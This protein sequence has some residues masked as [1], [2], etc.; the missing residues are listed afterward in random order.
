M[1]KIDVYS[2]QA[3][4]RFQEPLTVGLVGAKVRLS[5]SNRWEALVKTVVFRQGDITR[6][7]AGV[8]GSAVIPWEVIHQPGI[9]VEIG[10]YGTDST[11]TVVI[12]TVWVRTDPVCAA[13]DPEQ[14]PSTAPSLEVWAQILAKLGNLDALETEGRTD[15][16]SAINEVK[17]SVCLVRVTG[18]GDACT[19]DRT[20]QELNAAYS[21]GKTL[22]C[23]WTE[24]S[25]FL[26]LAV[27][28]QE[29]FHFVTVVQ[30]TEYDVR[31]NEDGIN[32]GTIILA[33]DQDKLPNPNKLTFTGAVEAEYDG[34]TPLRVEIPKTLWVTVT[35][36]ADGTYRADKTYEEIFAAQEAGY[37]V[38]CKY[39]SQRYPLTVASWS[40]CVFGSIGRTGVYTRIII[41]SNNGILVSAEQIAGAPDSAEDCVKTVNGIAPDD[42]G[43]VAIEIAPAAADAYSHFEDL[44]DY[45][46]KIQNAQSP[47]TLTLAMM[48]DTHY[49][50]HGDKPQTEKLETAN[51]MAML[52]NYVYVDALVNLGDMVDGD[53]PRGYTRRDLAQLLVNTHQNAK[54][55]VFYV[56]GNHDDNG[57]YSREAEGYPGTCKPEEMI[58]HAQWYQWA[59]GFSARDVV[60][61]GSNPTGGYGYFD[62]E[63]SKIR[64][65]LL[66]TSDFP[67]V[68][69][70]GSYRYNAYECMAFSNAQLNFVAN[71][72]RFE[73]KEVPNDWAAMF[74]M[75]IPLDA[76]V[77]DRRFGAPMTAIRGYIQMHSI[78]SAYRKGIS[79]K[80]DGSVNR[81]AVEL[82]EHF[83]VS[84]DAD[85]SQ[86]GCGDVICFVSGHTHID[87]ASRKV[88]PPHTLSHGYTYLSVGSAASFSTMVVDREKST[89]SVFKYGKAIGPSQSTDPIIN[90]NG[91]ILVANGE[92]EGH[93][94]TSG[95]WVVPFRQF[96]PRGENLLVGGAVLFGGFTVPERT[97]TDTLSLAAADDG[98][99]VPSDMIQNDNYA[100]S[101]AI[102]LKQNTQYVIPDIGNS[103]IYS[104]HHTSL[105]RNGQLKPAALGGEYII[106]GGSYSG[107]YALFVFDKAS[108]PDYANFTIKERVH[109]DVPVEPEVV[110]PPED[111]DPD[112]EDGANDVHTHSYTSSVTKAAACTAPGIRTYT[113]ACGHSYTQSIPA[114]GHT[115]V[116]GVCTAC[117][118]ADPELESGG[119]HTEPVE[120]NL[121]NGMSRWDG[122]Y[123]NNAATLDTQTLELSTADENTKWAISKAVAVEPNTEYVIANIGSG[124]ILAYK[125]TGAHNGSITPTAGDGCM[126]FVSKPSGGYVVFVFHKPTY[127]DFDNFYMKKADQ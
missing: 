91:E 90:D 75:H 43:N 57:L 104:F 7:V 20:L 59:F 27:K 23:Y 113:C 61:D 6:T 14:D 32:C 34:S 54:C 46:R 119:D 84:V 26:P 98:T 117:G 44:Q 17:Q 96:R 42:G 85:Y 67:Y 45:A 48:A 5:F 126:T 122:H 83:R 86:K 62:H 36:N 40:Q 30:N 31:L 102:L 72:L 108:Y 121:F 49:C 53:E 21:A 109:S 71:A 99:L 127:S 63:A 97:D 58:D 112:A 94:F 123:I 52:S 110:L 87:N 51:K 69:E 65:F 70:N 79:Y 60:T 93:V 74:L 103:L 35:D 13:V 9:P 89:V 107:C 114:T 37:I 22:L 56:R 16:V 105:K 111:A 39:G 33:T 118:A 77:E 78:I 120:G 68:L 106:T 19:A 18:K 115:Y 88:G 38:F 82:P 29:G 100:I 73:D 47:G 11:G 15:L 66:N 81:L 2:T 55:P 124:Q 24:H 50:G 64:V 28:Y 12:P 76:Y 8:S 1:L 92:E 80:F 4:I 95:K 25:I 101:E 125:D 41:G 10:F 3:A 116:D